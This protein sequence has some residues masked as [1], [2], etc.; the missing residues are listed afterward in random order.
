MK[1]FDVY[2]LPKKEKAER[3]IVERNQTLVGIIAGFITLSATLVVNSCQDRENRN[4]E[5]AHQREVDSEHEDRSLCHLRAILL[6]EL[7]FQQNQ[8]QHAVSQYSASK[9]KGGATGFILLPA[10]TIFMA[11]LSNLSLL[12][13]DEA[14]RVYAA[15]RYYQLARTQLRI[16]SDKQGGEVMYFSTMERASA[17]TEP[18]STTLP[19]ISKAIQSLERHLKPVLPACKTNE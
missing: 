14:G 19:I 2:L 17:V 3:S 12:T 11:N 4:A 8:I 16:S 15:E 10:D 9:A 13:T 5:Y 1:L 7:L 18:M 6:S